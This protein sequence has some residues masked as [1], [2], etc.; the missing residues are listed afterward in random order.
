MCSATTGA[1]ELT[2]TERRDQHTTTTKTAERPHLTLDA[3][4]ADERKG[5]T[6]TAGAMAKFLQPHT[7]STTTA[8]DPNLRM[9]HPRLRG[10]TPTL[11]WKSVKIPI[12]R[13]P[14][15]L[16]QRRSS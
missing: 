14:Q 15:W 4:K 2:M 13:R 9:I 7:S 10:N 8:D 11:Y 6:N 12:H 1:D 16:S 5:S 3:D